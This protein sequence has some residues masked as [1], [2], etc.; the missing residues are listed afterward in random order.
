MQKILSN[1]IF[2]L[3]MC[4]TIFKCHIQLSQSSTKLITGLRLSFSHH[5]RHKRSHIF[6]DIQFAVEDMTLR[7]Q[8]T[9]FLI[10]LDE[11]STFLNSIQNIRV[12]AKSKY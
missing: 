1:F 3:K 12:K 5:G 11:R 7:V 8:L 4:N 6:Q 2:F 10:Y 9:T